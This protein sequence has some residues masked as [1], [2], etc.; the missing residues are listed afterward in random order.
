MNWSDWSVGMSPGFM[1][2]NESTSFKY[3]FNASLENSQFDVQVYTTY[4]GGNEHVT[5]Q[6]FGEIDSDSSLSLSYDGYDG[7]GTE[8]LSKK[9]LERLAKNTKGQ[10]LTVEYKRGEQDRTKG[11]LV[12]VKCSQPASIPL[13]YSVFSAV[14]IRYLFL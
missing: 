4:F 10:T 14:A 9:H 2:R 3:V 1:L 11:V 7:A 12:R 13:L 6:M 5:V 8:I